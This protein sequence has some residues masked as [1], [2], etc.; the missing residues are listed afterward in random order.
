LTLDTGF[1]SKVIFDA[2]DVPTA[3]GDDVPGLEATSAFSRTHDPDAVPGF[4][5]PV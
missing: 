1:R 3:P 2:P 4:K 5:Q